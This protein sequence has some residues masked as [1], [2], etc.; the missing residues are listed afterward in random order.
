M[1]LPAPILLADDDE[2][3]IFLMGR[4]FERAGSRL[5]LMVV[6]NG[7]EAID[8]LKAEGT[9]ADRQAYPWPCLL[10]LDLKMPL[11]D[12]FEVLT[13]LQKRRRRQPLRVVV[14]SSS[15]QDADIQRALNLGA[16]AYCAKPHDFHEMVGIACELHQQLH[17][18][19]PVPSLASFR[20]S[21]ERW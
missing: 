12:G 18:P 13:W 3:D 5:P 21:E 15:Q 17:Q 11:L 2:N 16:D 8:Y 19:A 10:L 4:A 7:Q 6:R 1:T 9:Y 14:L 20:R